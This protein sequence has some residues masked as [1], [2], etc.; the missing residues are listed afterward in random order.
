MTIEE[1]EK[2]TL[3][4]IWALLGDFRDQVIAIGRHKQIGG[5]DSLVEDFEKQ[6]QSI[7]NRLTDM[8]KEYGCQQFDKGHQNRGK[9]H[10]S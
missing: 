8:I 5:L 6:E 4:H 10:D 7:Y 3:G 1:I 9:K 2:I